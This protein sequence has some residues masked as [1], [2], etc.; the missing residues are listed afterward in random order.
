MQSPRPL[1]PAV[2]A[3]ARRQAGLVSAAQLADAGLDARRTR[4]KV[5][6]GQL[7]RACRGVYDVEPTPPSRRTPEWARRRGWPEP[8][9]VL[10][11]GRRRTALLA[12]LARGP[13]AVAVGLAALALHGVQG[14]PLAYRADVVI[15][16]TAPRGPG[17]AGRVRRFRGT[18][19]TTTADGWA[20]APLPEALAQAVL[21]LSTHPRGRDHA[22]AIMDDVLHRGLL[23]PAGL[24]EARR[25]TWHRPGAQATRPW[26]ELADGRAESPAETWARLSCRDAGIP[27][28]A[29]QLDR[30]DAAGRFVG[31][32]DMAWRL[33]DGTWLLVEIDGQAVHGR[34]GALVRDADRQNRLLTG[35]DVLLRFSGSAAWRGEVAPGVAAVLRPR[36]WHPRPP[37]TAR[38]PFRSGVGGRDA[39]TARGACRSPRAAG[40]AARRGTAPRP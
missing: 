9:D 6:Q 11:E 34:P 39:V 13:L 29:L 26:W 15:R 22:V 25:F 14:L 35:G 32:V 33:A 28:D 36:G 30:R 40:P 23:T 7:V 10:A 27:P 17:G 12:L 4:E 20:V 24:R 16:T 19:R 21:A 3:L 18:A 38:S 8:G 1:P 5:A 2:L 31:R 37:L